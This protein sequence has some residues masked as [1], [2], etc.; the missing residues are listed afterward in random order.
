MPVGPAETPQQRVTLWKTV[1][2]ARRRWERR[3]T[4]RV[5]IRFEQE[6]AV[7]LRALKQGRSDGGAIVRAELA[8]NEQRVE[9]EP[10]ITGIYFDV[11]EPFAMRS[12]RGLKGDDPVEETKM[13]GDVPPIEDLWRDEVTGWLRDQSGQKI[14]LITDTT[15]R[16]VGKALSEGVSSGESI[17]QLANRLTG[18]YGGEFTKGRAV[19]IAQTEVISA[20]NM[21]SRAGALSTGLDLEHFWIATPDKRTRRDHRNANGQTKPMDQPYLVGV[22]RLMFPGDTSLGASGRNVV[23]CRCT[24]GYR[25]AVTGA[26]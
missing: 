25:K 21:G 7:V 16:A 24:E 2:R 1:D 4:R 20:S 3:I 10:M 26:S 19:I 23:V 17:A 5:A 13:P 12:L 22:D 6:R 11:G 15:R 9:W 18:L 8:I 14:R